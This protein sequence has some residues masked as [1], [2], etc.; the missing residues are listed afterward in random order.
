MCHMTF[1]EE[2]KKHIRKENIGKKLKGKIDTY[3][4]YQGF[5]YFS[6]KMV[7]QC[8][9]K[10]AILENE[11]EFAEQFCAY[12]YFRIPDFR[13]KLLEVL[14]QEGDMAIDDW[15]NINFNNTEGGVNPLF[16]WQGNFYGPISHLQ[17]FQ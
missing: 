15:A 12:A 3:I 4:K 17:K 8:L 11:R 6:L 14:T 7:L 9:N 2:E 1:S 13:E 5:L 16:D 10:K